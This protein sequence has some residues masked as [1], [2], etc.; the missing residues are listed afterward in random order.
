MPQILRGHILSRRLFFWI[1]GMVGVFVLP[2]FCSFVSAQ[3]S[4]KVVADERMQFLLNKHI[5]FNVQA[6]TV[7]GYR[8]RVAAFSGTG[9]KDKAFELKETLL[10][11]NQSLQAYVIYDDPNF[12]VKWGDFISRLDAYA[13]FE[14]IKSLYPDASIVRDDV[15][16]PKLPEE[17]LITPEELRDAMKNQ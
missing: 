1:G 14:T 3:G 15:N 6:R 10:G 5:E 4:V 8:V 17:N 13:A 9:A 11:Q 16:L 7:Q 2:C 12:I